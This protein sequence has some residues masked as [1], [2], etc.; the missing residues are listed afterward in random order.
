VIIQAVEKLV[1][2]MTE[3]HAR[4]EAKEDDM[5]A[6]FDQFVVYSEMEK[7]KQVDILKKEN[8]HP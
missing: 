1:E 3:T 5:L 7:Q 4:V 6:Q 2:S 8:N